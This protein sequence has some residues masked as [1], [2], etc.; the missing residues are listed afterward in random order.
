MQTQ[1]PALFLSLQIALGP[2]GVGLQGSLGLSVTG[3]AE[4]K[5]VRN[6]KI[7]IVEKKIFYRKLK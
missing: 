1:D 7:V 6:K 2:H 5:Y 4:K 3:R